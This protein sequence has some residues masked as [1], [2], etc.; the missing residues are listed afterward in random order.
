MKLGQNIA[1]YKLKANVKYKTVLNGITSYHYAP[2]M[3]TA[4]FKLSLCSEV[5]KPNSVVTE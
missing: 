1:G 2:I 5:S 3:I 4:S